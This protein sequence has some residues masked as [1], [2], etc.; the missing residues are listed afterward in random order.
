MLTP[1]QID[2][3]KRNDVILRNGFRPEGAGARKDFIY[4][5]VEQNGKTLFVKYLPQGT[6][7][8]DARLVAQAISTI[9]GLPFTYQNN[10]LETELEDIMLPQ[11]EQQ[12]QTIVDGFNHVQNPNQTFP[13]QRPRPIQ[14]ASGRGIRN[15]QFYMGLVFTR[16]PF[17]EGVDLDTIASG[18]FLNYSRADVND[19]STRYVLSPTKY[20]FGQISLHSETENVNRWIFH[21]DD[22]EL[23]GDALASKHADHLLDT[24]ISVTTCDW[25]FDSKGVSKMDRA[26]DRFSTVRGMFF[27]ED[28]DIFT[29]NFGIDSDSPITTYGKTKGAQ[30]AMTTHI[31]T[32]RDLGAINHLGERQPYVDMSNHGI[33]F[34]RDGNH[35]YEVKDVQLQSR[36]Q[37][38]ELHFLDPFKGLALY[39]DPL[40]E[41]RGP[42]AND[43]MAKI[44]EMRRAVA[45]RYMVSR[46]DGNGFTVQT[47]PYRLVDESLWAIEGAPNCFD[48]SQWASRLNQDKWKTLLH[49]KIVDFFD[50]NARDDL[51]C[52]MHYAN[53]LIQN[54]QVYLD[55]RSSGWQNWPDNYFLPP[56]AVR[57]DHDANEICTAEIIP[58][59]G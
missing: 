36:L 28:D 56:Y 2:H 20:E 57:V 53:S 46:R 55:V 14:N 43:S 45:G 48:R 13:A 17:K 32:E 58:I 49:P 7:P 6:K 33:Y 19:R 39:A 38:G 15:S 35:T 12:I 42:N 26:L 50:D 22:C 11:N 34:F 44:R 4:A 16:I 29:P 1:Q 51:T 30:K 8:N 41:S 37:E 24:E 31:F 59:K 52:K 3:W 54:P 21:N 10:R 47:R 9:S 27:E 5:E 40:A 18:P 25:E 23:V